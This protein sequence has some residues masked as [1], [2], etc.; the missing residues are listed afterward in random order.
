MDGCDDDGYGNEFYRY[1]LFRKCK[2]DFG[3]FIIR[4]FG[5]WR[6]FEFRESRF[7]RFIYIKVELVYK[8]KWVN[9]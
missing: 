9:I 7:R 6:I 1:Y 8:L 5:F 4:F 2:L 3:F